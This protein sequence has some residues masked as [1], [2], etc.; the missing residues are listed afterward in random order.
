MGSS[1]DGWL[2][3]QRDL[4]HYEQMKVLLN[5]L[6]IDYIECSQDGVQVISME[7]AVD[8][9]QEVLRG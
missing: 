6:I 1:E 8:N 2:R 4:E 5:R 9:L 7:D 3:M